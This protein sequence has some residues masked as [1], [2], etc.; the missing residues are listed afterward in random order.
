[1]REIRAAI[2]PYLFVRETRRSLTYLARDLLLVLTFGW[3]ATWIDS[4]G[5]VN[6]AISATIHES[7]VFPLRCVLWVA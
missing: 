3:L 7:Y 2:P 1:M 5:L 4:D 6:N